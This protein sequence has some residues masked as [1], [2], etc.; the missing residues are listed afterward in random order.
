MHSLAI[1]STSGACEDAVTGVYDSEAEC[2]SAA[3][4]DRINGEC[5]QIDYV[6]KKTDDKQQRQ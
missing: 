2:E 6:V 1:C 3:F 4:E 5:F